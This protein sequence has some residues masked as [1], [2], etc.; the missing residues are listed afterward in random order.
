MIR[1]VSRG[2]DNVEDLERVEK[3][4]AERK[5]LSWMGVQKEVKKP[6]GHKNYRRLGLE[7][8]CINI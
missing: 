8:D 2:I 3:E 1:A 5:G 6:E 4:E 7:V